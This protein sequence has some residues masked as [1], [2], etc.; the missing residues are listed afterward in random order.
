MIPYCPGPHEF[1]VRPCTQWMAFIRAQSFHSCTMN[2]S[3]PI[4]TM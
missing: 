2:Q 3:Q 4:C 1:S